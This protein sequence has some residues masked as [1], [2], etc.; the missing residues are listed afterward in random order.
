MRVAFS[1][2]LKMK[3][4]LVLAIL[5]AWTL[6]GCPPKSVSGPAVKMTTP[7]LIARINDNNAL[8]TNLWSRLDIKVETPDEKHSISGHLILRK[9]AKYG[10]PPRDLLLKG[11]DTWGAAEF[12]LGSN[13]QEYWYMLKTPRTDPPVYSRV[14]Y[15]SSDDSAMQASQ[16]LDLLSVLGVYELPD[17][18]D[19]QPWPVCR[20]YDE[21]AYY[22][23]SFVERT[24]S[25]SLRVR[26]DVWWNR[27]SQH[28]DLIELFDEQGQRYLSAALD[29]YRSFDGP[30]LATRIRITWFEEKLVLDLK[31][32]DVQV[33]SP[34]VTDKNFV[35]R[36][37]D[38]AD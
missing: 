28:V 5:M 8:I 11:G 30:K 13:S 1:P 37:P 3:L 31:L 4:C 22:V 9:P 16:A 33:R 38:W 10:Q 19:Q 21:P 36:K 35:H 26:K 14:P 29:D 24:D 12:Q 25:G 17:K 2:H 27:R 6:C 32:K 20:G 34:K 15:D 23:I 18:L 7:D